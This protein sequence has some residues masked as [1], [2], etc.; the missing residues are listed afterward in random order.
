MLLD[1]YIYPHPVLSRVADPVDAFDE[2]LSKLVADMTETMYEGCG[3]GLAAPQVGVSR[4]IFIVDTSAES[5]QPSLRAYINPKIILKG[6][7]V[8]WNEGCL[9]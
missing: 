6:S 7:P 8:V 3:V 5:E 1:L 4:Q 2:A 9:S